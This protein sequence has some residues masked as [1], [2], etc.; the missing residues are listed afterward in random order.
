MNSQI[1]EQLKEHEKQ[2]KEAEAEGFKSGLIAVR[3]HSSDDLPLCKEIHRLTFSADNPDLW[4][5]A[6]ILP[7]N[8]TSAI[9]YISARRLTKYGITAE[10]LK[11]NDTKLHNLLNG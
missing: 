10:M 11:A 6:E 1:Y 3:F 7:D 2:L 4:Q 8:S 5:L 9:N